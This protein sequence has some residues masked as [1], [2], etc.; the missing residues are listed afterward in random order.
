MAR[1]KANSEAL[2][3]L[4]DLVAT[5]LTNVISKGG[6]DAATIGAAIRFLK[7]NGI[8]AVAVPDSPLRKLLDELDPE[9]V[10]DED[11]ERI[12]AECQGSA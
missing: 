12:K 4:H 2:E 3:G 7:D 1:K 11:Y 6:W 8:T 5:Q 10:S 9:V